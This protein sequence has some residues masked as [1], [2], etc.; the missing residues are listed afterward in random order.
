M[1]NH[2]DEFDFL[3]PLPSPTLGEPQEDEFDFLEPQLLPPITSRPEPPLLAQGLAEETEGR[4]GRRLTRYFDNQRSAQNPQGIPTIGVG[5][6]LLRKGNRERLEVLGY[7]YTQVL[8]GTQDLRDEDGCI[9]MLLLSYLARDILW[10]PQQ[11]DVSA[12]CEH[13]QT[14]LDLRDYAIARCDRHDLWQAVRTAL[15]GEVNEKRREL[16][17]QYRAARGRGVC[18]Q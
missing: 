12:L 5:F 17:S 9:T 14:V 2:P 11:T 10:S 18:R 6:N 3:V 15:S 13:Y 7:D 1:T 4:E 8:A 16:I